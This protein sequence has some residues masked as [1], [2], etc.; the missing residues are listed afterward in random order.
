MPSKWIGFSAG[1]LPRMNSMS[2]NISSRLAPRLP[3][4]AI[5]SNG[6]D[7]RYAAECARRS[8]STPPCTTAYIACC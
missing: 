8:L 2:A 5:P 7:E 3:P 4:M 1:S 6:S